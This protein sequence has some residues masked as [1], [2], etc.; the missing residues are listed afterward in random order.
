MTLKALQLARKEIEALRAHLAERDAEISRLSSAFNR[1]TKEAVALLDEL[2]KA[3]QQLT[4]AQ[5]EIERL[6]AEHKCVS[7]SAENEHLQE[8]LAAAQAELEACRKDV[9][10]LKAPAMVGSVRFGKGVESRLVIEAAQRLYANEVTPEKEAER[11][12]RARTSLDDF[13]KVGGQHPYSCTCNLCAA[14]AP[15]EKP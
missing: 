10:R 15:K 4:Q 13:L 14:A 11:I 2:N 3:E 9:E 1:R 5:A 8:Q 12:R 7:W 6:K